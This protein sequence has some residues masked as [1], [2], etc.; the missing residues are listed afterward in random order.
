MT[1]LLR[2]RAD[3]KKTLAFALDIVLK[4]ITIDL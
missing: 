2:K 3:D 1:F 4:N